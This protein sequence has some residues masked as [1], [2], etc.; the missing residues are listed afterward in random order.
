[1]M[2]PTSL[3]GGPGTRKR[4]EDGREG[5]EWGEWGRSCHFMYRNLFPFF[6]VLGPEN[7]SNRSIAVIH[8]NQMKLG[9]LPPCL[10]LLGKHHS[11]VILL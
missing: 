3:G 2:P 4:K 10:L 8:P 7:A 11:L 1:M 9:R 6:C 5:G